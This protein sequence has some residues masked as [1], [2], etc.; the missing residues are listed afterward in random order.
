MTRR[1]VALVAA[2][3][4]ACSAGE[5]EK[6][7]AVPSAAVAT[8]NS[9]F[10]DFVSLVKREGAAVVNLSTT[11]TVRGPGIPP[12]V[13]PEDPF[14]EFFRRFAPGPREYQARSLGSGFVISEDGYILTNAH[15]VADIDE[16]T[17]KLVDKRQFK[18][19]VI[20]VDER[21]D[22]A[23]VK[24][25]A[26]GLRKVTIGDPAKLEAGEWVAA[27]G[28]PF[29]FE[30]S[31]TAGIVSAKG[32]FF[33]D[34]SEV[35]FIQTD[36][37]VNPG[38]SGGPLFNL[39][40][41]VVGINSMIYSGSG[42]YMGLS[43]AIPIDVA[44]KVADQLRTHGKV[45][46]GRLGVQIQELTDELAASFKLKSATGALIVMVE[47][48]S[49]ADRAGLAPGDVILRVDGKSIEDPSELSRLIAATPPATSVRLAVWRRGKAMELDAT[50][51]EL[52]SERPRARAEPEEARADR[53]G[54]VLGELTPSERRELGIERGLLVR[55]VR[56]PA[57]KAGI[58]PGD[59]IVAINDAPV[60]RVVEY[61][62]ALAEAAPGGVVALL[63]LREGTLVYVPVRLP[64]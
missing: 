11:R 2:L 55:S 52:V 37:A 59:A 61:N 31:V 17:V 27:I 32:R 21:T 62:Q 46:R 4:V 26:R 57:L 3:L 43:F 9:T 41:E 35:P 45:T 34:E 8:G 18:A 51:G 29:G 54:L 13:S 5:P 38:N 33:P 56:G 20:G 16:A 19:K 63:V 44:M 22:V 30:S 23:L 36:V 24:I 42:G 15:L 53:L 64:S 50:V 10:P 7:P 40:G 47:K 6:S 58:R 39:R 25:D 49:P 28:S 60:S 48:G 12:G 1:A 14:Y